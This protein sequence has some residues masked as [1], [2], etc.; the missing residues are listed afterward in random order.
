[1]LMSVEVAAVRRAQFAK[2]ALQKLISCLYFSRQM[3]V[4]SKTMVVFL[5]R[6]LRTPTRTSSR[7]LVVTKQKTMKRVKGLNAA[8]LSVQ[9]KTEKTRWR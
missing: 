5:L 8:N 3:T 6:L 9:K 7:Q 2:V 4:V 1:M